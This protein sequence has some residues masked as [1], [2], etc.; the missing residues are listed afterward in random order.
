M[1]SLQ[2][3]RYIPTLPFSAVRS[4]R[5]ARQLSEAKRPSNA[6]GHHGKKNDPKL[7]F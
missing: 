4:I 1:F 3:P 5:R 6:I 7:P 2:P